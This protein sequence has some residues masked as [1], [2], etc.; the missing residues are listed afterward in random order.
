MNKYEQVI[1]WVFQQNYVPGDVRVKF[2]RG[3]LEDAHDELDL[4]QTKNIG[5]IIYSFRFRREL[6]ASIKDTAPNQAEWVIVGTGTAEYQFQLSKPSRIEPSLHHYPIPIPEAT[7]EII[8]QYTPGEDEQALLARV[9][10]NRLVD[11]FTGLTCY[12][13]QNH[14]RT[15][16]KGIGQ[17]EVDEV[18]VGLKKKGEHF[19]LPCQAKSK[20][21]KFDIVQVMQDIALCLDRFPKATCRPIALQFI[22]ENSVAILELAI[23]DQEEILKLNIIDEKHNVLVPRSDVGHGDDPVNVPV[24]T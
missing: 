24:A 16:V 13:I 10:Y 14:L 23:R 9:R 19:V 8:R 15:S 17:I 4:I 3:E 2:T 22:N 11:I 21:E 6:P 12:S 1:S 5:D 18:Y 7:P 20:G